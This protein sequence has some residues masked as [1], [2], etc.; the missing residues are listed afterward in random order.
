[1]IVTV[2]TKIAARKQHVISEW[3]DRQILLNRL[4]LLILLPEIEPMRGIPEIVPRQGIT[5]RLTTPA[6]LGLIVAKA[7]KAKSTVTEIEPR[8][9]ITVRLTTALQAELNSTKI[10][11]ATWIHTP[12]GCQKSGAP[13][14]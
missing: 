12:T 7:T 10:R 3:T 6:E 13:T 11:C 9:G 2:T 4:I 5:V 14:K 1:M 8:Q